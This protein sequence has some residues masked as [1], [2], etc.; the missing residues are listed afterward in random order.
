[1]FRPSAATRQRGRG[2]DTLHRAGGQQLAHAPQQK[3]DIR[4]LT[5][6]VGMEFVED[7]KLET[8]GRSDELLFAR[9]GEHEFQHHIVGEQDVRRARDDARACFLILLARVALERDRAFA[10]RETEVQE[11]LQLAKLAVG[12]GVHRVDDDG[13]NPFAGTVAQNVVHDGDD[14]GKTFARAR[15]SGEDVVAILL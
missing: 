3:G 7:E 13:L 15:A 8:F 4:A 5:A 1:M 11:F 9:P 2:A 6:A 14:V 12:E 10:V